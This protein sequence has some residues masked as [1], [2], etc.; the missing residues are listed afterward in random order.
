MTKSSFFGKKR[1]EHIRQTS[2]PARRLGKH[3]NAKIYMWRRII[4]VIALLVTLS[5]AG[6]IVLGF[7]SAEY[8]S[9]ELSGNIHYNDIQN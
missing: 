9:L 3:P 4:L 5:F 6:K 8:I 1:N 7:F 2:M